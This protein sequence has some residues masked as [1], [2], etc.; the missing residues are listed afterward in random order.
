MTQERVRPCFAFTGIGCRVA[1]SQSIVLSPAKVGITVPHPKHV[2]A[3]SQSS[4]ILL[5][6]AT[7]CNLENYPAAC[8]NNKQHRE[9]EETH[10]VLVVELALEMVNDIREGDEVGW[11]NDV[12]L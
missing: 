5:A 3:A 8:D 11:H 2:P 10:R 6:I 9:L 12:S 4:Q 7:S 1:A